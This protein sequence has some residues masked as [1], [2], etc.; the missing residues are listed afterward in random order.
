MCPRGKE[1]IGSVWKKEGKTWQVIERTICLSH[2]R[3]L[4]II[5]F[6]FADCGDQKFSQAQLEAPAKSA[7]KV[8]AAGKCVS[9]IKNEQE[10]G[11]FVPMLDLG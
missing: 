6:S 1:P 3:G 7:A 10:R 2:S 5:T 8:D 11:V 9:L 4:I